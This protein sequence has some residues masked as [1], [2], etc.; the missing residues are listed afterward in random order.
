M[1][2]RIHQK[3]FSTTV[4]SKGRVRKV[5]G[6]SDEEKQ[7]PFGNHTGGKRKKKRKHPQDLK[8]EPAPIRKGPTDR[9]RQKTGKPDGDGPPPRQAGEK[10]IDIH[11]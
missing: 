11:V 1:L 7:K 10:R 8:A 6:R 3:E 5:R 9:I 4:S 2:G